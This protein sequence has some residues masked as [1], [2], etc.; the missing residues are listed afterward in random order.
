MKR[1]LTMNGNQ[2]T[3]ILLYIDEEGE[4]SIDG[5]ADENRENIWVTLKSMA[6][7]F[8]VKISTI[9]YHLDN[10]FREGELKKNSV[11]ANFATPVSDDKNYMVNFYS[12]DAL[13]SVGYRVESDNAI[14]FRRG[15]TGILNEYI[16]KGFVLN[17]DRLKNESR[18]DKQYFT[19]LLEELDEIR[20]SQRNF[21][22]KI[23]DLYATS[24]DYNKNAEITRKF[25]MKVLTSLHYPILVDNGFDNC[26]AD[27]Q[28][29][30]INKLVDFF[31]DIAELY[32]KSE[33][34]ISME[35][36]VTIM[37]IFF[38]VIENI[39][40]DKERFASNES[41]DYFKRLNSVLEEFYNSNSD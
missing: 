41:H 33:T 12:F 3:R 5:I 39:L 23:T 24:Y 13:I 17:D 30:A 11:V 15:L 10:I 2:I 26:L 31:I 37:N 18:F 22:E 16:V 8:D 35:D 4:V 1:S 28:M 21:C 32:A 20:V 7:F 14:R 40:T 34:P 27:E 9:R 6:E 25:Y 29:V 19:H 38:D 36:W